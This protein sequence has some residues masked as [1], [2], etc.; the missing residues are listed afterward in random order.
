[1]VVSASRFTCLDSILSSPLS[2]SIFPADEEGDPYYYNSTTG[3]TVW[4]RPH[5]TPALATP[6]LTSNQ[7]PRLMEVRYRYR[8]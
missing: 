3:E 8:Y 1:M 4:D 7:I 5:G 6:A 2:S